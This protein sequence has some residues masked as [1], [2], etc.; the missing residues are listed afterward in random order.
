MPSPFWAR[1]KWRPPRGWLVDGLCLNDSLFTEWP[2]LYQAHCGGPGAAT[3]EGSAIR[4]LKFMVLWA[5]HT[6]QQTV[7]VLLCVYVPQARPS[8][9]W[10]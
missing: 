5:R 4:A 6:T 2:H 1:T 3:K 8:A 10:V 9:G 7:M